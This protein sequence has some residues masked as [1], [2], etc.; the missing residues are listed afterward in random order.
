MA[1]KVD[2]TEADKASEA[3]ATSNKRNAFSELM[4][5]K[6]KQPKP[7]SSKHIGKLSNPND[8]RNGLLA[9]I[10]EPA[11]YYPNI[12]IKYDDRFVLIRDAFPKATIHLLLLPRD[13]S[14]RDLHPRDALNDQD[15]LN[16]VLKEAF[17]AIELAASELSRQIGRYS[18]S[19]KA[20]IAAMESEELVD[21][22]PPSRDFAKEFRVGIHAHPSMNHLHIHIISR[23]MH[24]DRLKHQKHYNSFNTDFFIPLEDFPLAEDDIKRNT[25]YQNGN[26]KKEYKCWRCGKL[27][28]NKFKQL[29]EHLDEEFGAWRRE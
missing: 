22:L 24:S 8:P 3:V 28:G 9:Y 5:P 1:L 15:F 26:L 25:S 20:H 11:K 29:K 27:F 2:G 10:L 18:E 14:K 21:E 16:E 13:A 4:S 7:E 6:A 17:A 23:D 19:C 12:V